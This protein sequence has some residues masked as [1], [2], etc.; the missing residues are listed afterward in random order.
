MPKK[1]T[2]EEYIEQL[3]EQGLCDRYRPLEEYQGAKT[4]ILHQCLTCRHE[5]KIRPAD[6]KKGRGCPKCSNQ[7]I[8]TTE[9]YREQAISLGYEPLEEYKG[10]L[11]KLKHRCL[12]C[13]HEWKITPNALKKVKGCPKCS[14]QYI[15]TIEEYREQAISLGY[16]PLEEYKGVR[17]KIK[18]RCMTCSHEWKIRPADIKSGH[19]CP[20]CSGNYVPTN[21]EYREQAISLGYEP[22]EE[23]KSALV[24]IKHRCMTCEHEWKAQPAHIKKGT[25]CPN[26]ANTNRMEVLFLEKMNE[27]GIPCTPQKS[28][29]TLV[30]PYGGTLRFDFLIEVYGEEVLIEI[31]GIQHFKPVE[32][33]GGW[34]GFVKQRR[35]DDA[36]FK[37]CLRNGVQLIRVPNLVSDKESL[38]EQYI[39]TIQEICMR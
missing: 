5:W 26:C 39:K 32:Y 17:V 3:R 18:H 13:S 25:G 14:N 27:L 35:K 12:T 28:Y 11:V 34:S 7:Y 4:P 2:N 19:G 23:Y 15:P 8:P 20:K 24:K 21:E 22:L 33:W 6:I 29:D 1:L 30:S 10:T 31:D 16:E 9:E 36:K 37:W 38:L